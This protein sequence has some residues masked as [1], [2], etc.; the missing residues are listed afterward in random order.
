MGIDAFRLCVGKQ[1]RNFTAHEVLEYMS[2]KVASAPQGEVCDMG[3][4][5]ARYENEQGFPCECGGSITMTQ[6]IK[7]WEC[8]K[9]DFKKPAFQQSYQKNRMKKQDGYVS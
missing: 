9:C 6:D 5:D 4:D 3:H 8:D 1:P 7:F 2:S